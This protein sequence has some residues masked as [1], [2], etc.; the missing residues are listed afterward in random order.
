MKVWKKDLILLATKLIEKIADL[1]NGKGYFNS[2]LERN[3][4]GLVRQSKIITQQL[5]AI[6]I[7]TLLP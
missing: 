6:K 4:T 1:S 7:Q 3:N 2:Y 5:K